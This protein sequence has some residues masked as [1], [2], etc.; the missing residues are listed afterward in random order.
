MSTEDHPDWWKNVGGSNAKDSILERRSLVWNDNDVEAPDDPPAFYTC[1][2]YRGKFFPRGCRGMIEEIQIY[3]RDAGQDL[4]TLRY[5]PHPC[6][7]PFGEVDIT[8]LAGWSWVA[9]AVEEMWNYDSLFI[10]I[11]ECEAGTDWAYDNAL[12]YDGH[13]STDAGETWSDLAIRPF[14]RVVYTGETPGDVPISGIINNIRIPNV[15]SL[16]RSGDAVPVPALA[17]TDLLVPY[18]GA[19]ELPY[20]IMTVRAAAQSHQTA[21]YVIC[22]GAAAF[23]MSPIQLNARGVVAGTPGVSLTQ[24]GVA[25]QCTMVF[26]FGFEFRRELRIAGYNA[27][28]PQTMDAFV[29]PSLLT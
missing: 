13:R 10:W 9:A 1:A 11:Y 3:C 5:S 7:G 2:T 19:G 27:L 22:D 4:L 17:L 23:N 28:A 29:F 6:L 25:G 20:L 16:F 14:I 21:F 26:T 8:P 18:D 12:P 15:S 24:Y